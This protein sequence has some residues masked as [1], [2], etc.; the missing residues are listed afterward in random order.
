MGFSV[1]GREFTFVELFMVLA[2]LLLLAV[3][4]LP[5]FARAFG[6]SERSNCVNNLKE[7]GQIFTMYATESPDG[8]YPP[9]QL[10]NGADANGLNGAAA[11]RVLDVW[12]A[13]LTDPSI[14][15]CP[16]DVDNPVTQYQNE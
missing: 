4:L 15:S 12:P 6:V 1:A 16:A 9:L 14:L 3:V 2:I 5:A 7:W 8:K 10:E 11:P 13:Y